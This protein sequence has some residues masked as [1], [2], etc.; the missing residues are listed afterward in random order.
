V[1]GAQEGILADVLRSVGAHDAGGH[2]EDDVAMALHQGL[3]RLQ[4][5]VQSP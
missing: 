2:P 3:E 1:K 4:V 5:T